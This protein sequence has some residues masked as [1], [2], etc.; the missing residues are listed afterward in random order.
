VLQGRL[1]SAGTVSSLSVSSAGGRRVFAENIDVYPVDVTV[2][3]GMSGAPVVGSNDS[4]IGILSG[5]F[6]EGRGIAWAIPITY[7]T[8]LMQTQPLMKPP[9]QVAVWPELSLMASGWISL[10]RT[11]TKAFSGVQIAKLE[12]LEGAFPELRGGWT[13]SDDSRGIL[14]D[15]P[16]LSGRCEKV[17]HGVVQM[18]LDSLDQDQ[19]AIQGRLLFS[20][21]IEAHFTP[22]SNTGTSVEFQTGLCNQAVFND[23]LVSR[24]SLK[25]EGGV[26]LSAQSLRAA[27]AGGYVFSSIANVTDCDGSLCS[28][29]AFG[30]Q[31]TGALERISSSKLRWHQ[32]ILSKQN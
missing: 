7:V 25:T 30:T 26:T 19:A 29:Q 20:M 3:S 22:P 16:I 24:G 12:I 27:P 8:T 28:P 1:T 6:D 5:S 10:K 32:V 2:Y 23:R 14:Y 13:S 15:E 31:D 17:V 11:Y 9:N 18:H 4:V 21:S